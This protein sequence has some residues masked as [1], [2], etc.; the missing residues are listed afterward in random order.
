[1]ASDVEI[2]DAFDQAVV[3]AITAHTPIAK[4]EQ[5]IVEGTLVRV[6]ITH[7]TLLESMTRRVESCSMETIHKRIFSRMTEAEVRDARRHYIPIMPEVQRKIR[8][9]TSRRG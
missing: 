7:Q 5:K 3:R 9:L 2:W 1:M 6:R 4:L 8:A